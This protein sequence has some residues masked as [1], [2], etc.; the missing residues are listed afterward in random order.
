MMKARWIPLSVLLLVVSCAGLPEIRSAHGPAALALQAGCGSPFPVGK[1]QFVHAI[2]AN[3]PGGRKGFVMGVTVVSSKLQSMDCVILSPEGLVL[4][5]ARQDQ[6]LVIKR[7]VFP[8]E[9]KAFAEGLIRDVQLIFLRPDAS[10][11]ESGLLGNGSS[12]CRYQEPDGKIVDIITHSDNTWEIRE[13][14]EDGHLTRTV[15]AWSLKSTGSPDQWPAPERLKLVSHGFPNYE[16]TMT[17]V[18]AV[19]LSQ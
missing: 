1:W 3:L 12:V 16:L 15:K 19:L 7:A 13:Y 8:F 9:E 10:L 5:E 2:E 17:L 11:R 4:F 18:E 14:G 6:G